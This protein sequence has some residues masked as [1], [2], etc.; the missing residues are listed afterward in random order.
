MSCRKCQYKLIQRIYHK[1]LNVFYKYNVQYN[2]LLKIDKEY[3]IHQRY[4]CNLICEVFNL[5]CTNNLKPEQ[6]KCSVQT[7]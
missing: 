5:K 3:S 7:I 1:V 4:L 6:F 2:E